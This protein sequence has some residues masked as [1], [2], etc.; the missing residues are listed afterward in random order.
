MEEILNKLENLGFTN[1][2]SKVFLVLMKGHN[3]TAAEIAKDANIPRTSVYDI[4][5]YFT[6]KGLC[7]EI[8][9]PTKL[10]YEMIDPDVVEDKLRNEFKTT[11]LTYNKGQHDSYMTIDF[12]L[13]DLPPDT[14]VEFD[15]NDFNRIFLSN[16]VNGVIKLLDYSRQIITDI[17]HF[18]KIPK[19]YGKNPLS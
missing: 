7:N 17:D 15:G 6:A 4:L 9:T 3:M 1:Y 11:L 19:L 5:K 8:E 14:I 10:R 13:P 12:K 16:V 18:A 2:E